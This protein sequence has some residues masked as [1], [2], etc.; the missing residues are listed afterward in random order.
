VL[1]VASSAGVSA[2]NV[3]LQGSLDNTNL[4]NLLT[5]ALSINAANSVFS[6]NAA[7]YPARYVRANVTGTITGGTNTAWLASV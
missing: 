3:Q 4:Y 5:T 7:N 1:V 2:G 6:G